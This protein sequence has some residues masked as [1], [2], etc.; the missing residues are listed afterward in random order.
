MNDGTDDFKPAT[1]WLWSCIQSRHSDVMDSYPTC[2]FQPRQSDDKGE[3][4]MLSDIVPIILE[5]NRYEDVYSDVAWYT[6]KHGGSIQGIFWD[7]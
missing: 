4:K 6:L 1:A 7:G 5:Q 3:A 2:N